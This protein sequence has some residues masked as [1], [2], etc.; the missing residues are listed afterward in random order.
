MCIILRKTALRQEL[1]PHSGEKS[2]Q[3]IANQEVKIA[4]GAVDN[5]YTEQGKVN[6]NLLPLHLLP[7]ITSWHLPSAARKTA[8]LVWLNT[9]I[10]TK[11]WDKEWQW[12]SPCFS[13]F[14][15]DLLDKHEN[16][17]VIRPVCVSGRLNRRSL[18]QQV[19]KKSGPRRNESYIYVKWSCILHNIGGSDW[20]HI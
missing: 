12:F 6:T 17:S 8:R 5:I 9:W 15:T 7:S 13:S 3:I 18:D 16:Y 19:G 20:I 4:C 10:Y 11:I 1:T 2:A 14:H